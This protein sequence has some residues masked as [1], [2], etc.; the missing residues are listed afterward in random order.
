MSLEDSFS[1]GRGAARGLVVIHHAPEDR[2]DPGV[3][4]GSQVEDVVTPVPGVSGEHGGAAAELLLKHRH[5][6]IE[7]T[8][9]VGGVRSV[10]LALKVWV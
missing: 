6:L 2:L 4:G 5:N 7:N 10:L 3:F 1:T 9:V 8:A